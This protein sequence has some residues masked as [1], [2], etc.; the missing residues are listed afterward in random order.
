M[1]FTQSCP[2]LCN[3]IDCSPWNSPG[4]N[5]GVVSLSLLKMDLL[6]PGIELES[7]ALQVDSL[8]T[9]LLGKPIYMH[10]YV[11]ITFS[12]CITIAMDI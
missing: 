6:D 5:T 9:W 11:C 7:P 10:V 12:V 1:K 8:P 3:P 2:T 4:Q